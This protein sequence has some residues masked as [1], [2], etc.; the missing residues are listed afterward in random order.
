M[1]VGAVMVKACPGAESLPPGSLL[2]V[3]GAVQW[4]SPPSHPLL[5]SH[6]QFYSIVIATIICFVY[7]LA[8]LI[9]FTITLCHGFTVSKKCIPP[10]S[11]NGNTVVRRVQTG[12]HRAS[13]AGY[14]RLQS[15]SL[16]PAETRQADRESPTRGVNNQ[17]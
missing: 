13:N 3:T 10:E 17:Q 4:E 9:T 12:C 11:R 7:L 14:P 2:S 16:C 15:L 6:R 8:E 1:D 5:P